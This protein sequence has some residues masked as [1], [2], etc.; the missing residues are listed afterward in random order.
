MSMQRLVLIFLCIVLPIPVLA[1]DSLTRREGYL[2]MWNSI[3]RPAFET[4]VT[5]FKDV[6]E[7]S[8]GFLEISYGK[9]R[10][11]LDDATHFFPEDSMHLGDALLWLYR[12]RNVDELPGMQRE[13]LTLLME[14]Y[15]IVLRDRDLME[16][17]PNT[18][19][20]VSM[21]RSLDAMLAKEIHEVSFY[22]DDFHGRGTA[23]GETFDMNEITAAHRS[24]PH[25]TLVKV[26]NVDNGK[27]L[28]VRINDRGPYV[29]GR[30]MDL[31]L[32][33]FL[34]IEERSRGVLHATFERLGD[35]EFVDKCED[36]PRRY[37][38]RITKNVRFHRGVPH[39]F[40]LGDQLVLQANR[41][42]VVRGVTYPDGRFQRMQD[43]VGPK[44]KFFFTPSESGLFRFIVGNSDGRRREMRMNVSAC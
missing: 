8:E 37:Q 15:P 5:P 31:S 25:N 44:E 33:A 4:A 1:A 2:L 29:E 16:L 26:T 43:F 42:F 21:M 13:D 34:E 19:S 32:A 28:V 23:F 20:L 24:F 22:A 14:R 27:H 18:A 10:G 40:T 6:S 36:A 30:D 38:K 17:I 35:G 7:E 3:R 41:W 39:T 11:I 12:T 9:S